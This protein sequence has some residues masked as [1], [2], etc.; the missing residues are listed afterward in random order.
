VFFGTPD[1][2]FVIGWT[3]PITGTV[4][5]NWTFALAGS[6]GLVSG[7]GIGLQI[8]MAVPAGVFP[9]QDFAQQ[10]V[11]PTTAGPMISSI[12]GLSVTTGD[13]VYWVVDAWATG[14]TA[15]ITKASITITQVPEPSTLTLLGCA[16]AGL[17]PFARRK[18][19]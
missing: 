13:T 4:D 19:I 15:D 1:T 8:G 10:A 18:R 3:A 11:F 14:G 17:M 5:I 12:T 9:G 6:P 16:L 7:D 2:R